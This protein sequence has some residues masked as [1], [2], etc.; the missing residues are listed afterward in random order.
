M[1][2]K[3]KVLEI[4]S[5]NRGA[6]VSGENLSEKL[7]VSRSAIWKAVESLRNAGYKINAVTNKG[8]ALERGG[9]FSKDAVEKYLKHDFSVEFINSLGSSNAYM[10]EKARHNAVE[11]STVIAGCQSG[12]R[13]RRGRAFFSPA[14]SGAYFSV[15]LYPERH[16]SDSLY[17]TAAAASAVSLALEDAAGIETGIKWVNDIYS[18]GRKI[19]GILTEAGFDMESS[20][21]NYAVVGIGINIYE[22]KGGFPEELDGIAGAAIRNDEPDNDIRSKIVAGVLD[23]FYDMYM[24][25]KPFMPVYRERSIVTGRKITIEKNGVKREAYADFIDDKCRLH[26]EYENSRKEILNAGEVGLIL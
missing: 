15:L 14:G 11:F 21:V 13:G 23:N 8:Y 5:E 2:V 26:I 24:G 7:K 22:P 4:L 25:N 20:S 17:I 18:G 1:A 10:L 3:D 6:F 12:G 9:A 16:I 19:C